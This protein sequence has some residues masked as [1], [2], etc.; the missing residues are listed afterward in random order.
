[1]WRLWKNGQVWVGASRRIE[2]FHLPGAKDNSEIITK[3]LTIKTH[4]KK[5][6]HKY[7]DTMWKLVSIFMQARGGWFHCQSK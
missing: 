6:A 1:M 5:T 7:L 3:I 2:F 4:E